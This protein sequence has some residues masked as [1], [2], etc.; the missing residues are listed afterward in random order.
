MAFGFVCLYSLLMGYSSQ[1]Q[2]GVDFTL[3]QCADALVAALAG[4]AG[5]PIAQRAGYPA[6]FSLAA[7]FGIAACVVLPILIGRAAAV[8]Q[9]G[10]SR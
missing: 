4:F 7:M 10:A 3:F 2:A 8:E 6:T 9:P 5:G 1:R